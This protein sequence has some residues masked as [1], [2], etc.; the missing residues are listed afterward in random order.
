M[1]ITESMIRD[2]V[3]KSIR[4]METKCIRLDGHE[5][6]WR[7]LFSEHLDDISRCE[8]PADFE[9]RVN[10]VLSRG[11][12]SHVAFF[13]DSAQRA[14]ARYAINATFCAVD[15]REGSRWVFEDVHEGGPAHVA[16]VRPGD[17]LLDVEGEAIQP[18]TS[19]T[20]GLGTDPSLTIQSPDGKA[21]QVRLILPKAEPN[22]KAD[23]K[24]PMAEPTSVTAR[25]LEPGIGHVRIAFFPGVNGQR[26]AREL[27]RSLAEIADCTRLVIDLR[28][29]LGG[30]VGSLRLM[31]YLTP[32]RIPIGYSLTRKGEDRKWRPG[33]LAC[34]DRLPRTTLDMVRMAIR[35]KVIHRDR[36]IRLVTEGLGVKPF[37][38][39]IVMLVNEH[40]LSAGEMVAAFAQENGLAGIVGT[41]TGA[42]WWQLLGRPWVHSSSSGRRLVH[43]ARLNCRGPWCFAGPRRAVVH[44]WPSRRHRQPA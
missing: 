9:R 43:L 11:G 29:N 4:L 19:P 38:G 15:T 30:F 20:F 28:G 12:L 34:I 42:R 2:V 37:H 31:S 3:N 14:P 25:S 23:A 6:N 21:R 7:A 39:H 10:S 35:F 22:G 32:D 33:Q 40:T 8:S 5:P 27:D 36:S 26:F 41:R 16:G 17:I 18:P 13:H 24:P 44:R 1:P